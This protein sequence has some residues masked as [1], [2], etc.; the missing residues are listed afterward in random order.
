MFYISLLECFM[1]ILDGSYFSYC[2][3]CYR[4]LNSFFRVGLFVDNMGG[5]EGGEVRVGGLESDDV[6]S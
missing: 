6:E 2:W 3:M 5:R 1:N 4:T